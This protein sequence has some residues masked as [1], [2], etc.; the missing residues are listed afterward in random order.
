MHQGNT[1]TCFTIQEDTLANA[2]T[3]TVTMKVSVLMLMSACRS[4]PVGSM[5]YART[6]ME[7]I[8][9]DVK[10]D[11]QEMVFNA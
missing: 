6:Q 7:V 10:L 8:L 9:A 11:L 2:E 5:Q 3:V 1:L 4:Y